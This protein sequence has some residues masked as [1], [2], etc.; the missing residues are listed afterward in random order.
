MIREY[1][2]VFIYIY[3]YIYI[4]INIYTCVC[5]CVIEVLQIILGTCYVYLIHHHESQ[6]AKLI[7]IILINSIISSILTLL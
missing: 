3:I 5:E 2:R 7:N 6:P 4:Y 1:I